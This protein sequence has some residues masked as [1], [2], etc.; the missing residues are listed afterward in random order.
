LSAAPSL[1]DRAEQFERLAQQSRRRAEFLRESA[2]SG[3][4]G[5]TRSRLNAQATEED[6]A[7]QAFEARAKQL[8][9]KAK[10]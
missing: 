6:E 8:R 2:E 1:I 9:E 4:G 7:A 5:A 10:A 3:T